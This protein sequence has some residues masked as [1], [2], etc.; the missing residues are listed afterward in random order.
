MTFES[1]ILKWPGTAVFAQEVGVTTDLASKWR[2]ERGI[3]STHWAAVLNA[4]KKRGISLQAED[5]IAAQA[6]KKGR[7]KRRATA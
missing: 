4:A 2:R 3:P 7:K 5:L 1:I 6:A